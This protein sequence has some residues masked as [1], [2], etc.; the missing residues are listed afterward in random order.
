MTTTNLNGQ[1][2]LSLSQLDTSLSFGDNTG[3]TKR[4]NALSNRLTGVLSSSY[5]DSEV[6][7]ALRLLD[8]RGAQNVEDTRSSLKYDAQKEVIQANAQIVE[9]F[10]KVAKVR[11]AKPLN[12]DPY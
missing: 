4:S 8:A 6:R 7:D 11:F 2:G 3:V 9:D 1:N 5:T 12:L 10:G